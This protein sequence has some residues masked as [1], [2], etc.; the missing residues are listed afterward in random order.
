MVKS[1]KINRE[2]LQWVLEQPIEIQ[3]NVLSNHLDICKVVINSVLQT[4]VSELCG[5]RYRH[6]EKNFT[7][8]G[9]NHGSVRVGAQKIPMEVPRI[10]D[11]ET[12][13]SVPLALYEQI[14][15]LPE[16]KE[17]LLKSILHGI[18]M[19]DYED[20]STRLLESFGLSAANISRQFVEES[21]KAVEAFCQRKFSE[22][23]FVALFIDGKYLAGQQMVIVLGITD[24]GE[25]ILLSVIQSTTENSTVIKQMLSDLTERDFKFSEGIL[26]IIDGS[27]GIRKALQEMWGEKAVVQRC[28][29]HKRENVVSYLS[30][31]QQKEFRKK[32]Q[33]AYQLTDEK[34]AKNKLMEIGSE[35]KKINLHSYNSLMEGLDE[36]LTLHRLGL[37]EELGKSFTTTNCIES[38]NSHLVKYIHKVKRWMD[39]EQRSRWVISGLLEIEPRLQRVNGHKQLHRLS[40][41][42][43]QHIKS[44]NRISTNFET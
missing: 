2:Q 15:E 38:V 14:R 21:R 40:D 16:Q 41:A 44:L 19:R 10:R 23:T 28:Q 4:A 39:S 9:Y 12:K 13:Q 29:W 25:K 20:V 7:R 42:I 34:Q 32:M 31:N 35:L 33:N 24:K 6:D 43:A 11:T 17:E 1:S 37:R 18:S 5:E 30:E 27:K 26:C 36:T 22:H 8:W 3:L